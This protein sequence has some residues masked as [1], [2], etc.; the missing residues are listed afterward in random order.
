MRRRLSKSRNIR[1]WF[2]MSLF[3]ASRIELTWRRIRLRSSRG[4]RTLGRASVV[5]VRGDSERAIGC[6][7]APPAT[8]P[9]M[10]CSC[11]R[12][13]MHECRLHA[14]CLAN[15]MRL[16]LLSSMSRARVPA[17]RP[18]SRL[19]R[20]KGIEPSY[21][22][23]EAAVLPLNYTR[24]GRDSTVAPASLSTPTGRSQGAVQA[25]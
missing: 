13:S 1:R 4:E 8:G 15:R 22:A 14:I 20:V 11:A 12:R 16:G 23:W 10:H 18:E 21:E 2:G 24:I 9:S 3:S 17:Q 6:M 7:G 5:A 25:S 19:E